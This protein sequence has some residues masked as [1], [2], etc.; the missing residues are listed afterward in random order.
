MAAIQKRTRNGKVSY[1]VRFYD[2]HGRERSRTFPT[3]ALAERFAATNTADIV[4][5]DWVDPTLAG[6]PF[7]AYAD[8]WLAVKRAE[9]KEQTADGYAADLRKYVT[10]RLGSVPV[11][12]ITPQ[13]IDGFLASLRDDGVSPHK[14][15][16]LLVKVVRPVLNHA[17]RDGAIKANPSAP[18]K[19]G[20]PRRQRD[21]KVLTA[22]QVTAL[23]DELPAPYDTLVLF[24]AYTGLRWGEVTGL[25]MKRLDLLAGRVEVAEVLQHYK[26]EARFSEPKTK[27]SERT[28]SLPRFL[29]DVMRAYVADRDLGPDDLVF[30][31]PRGK[32]LRSPNFLQKVYI[33]AVHR[34]LPEHLHGFRFH[35]LR[36]T[37]VALLIGA[38]AHPKEISTRMGH[39]TIMVTMDTYGHLLPSLDDRLSDGL[40]AAYRGVSA[41]TA[42]GTVVPMHRE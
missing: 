22:A 4:R 1:R 38:G 23:V 34:A 15:R 8:A 24:T 5:G 20:K 35:D 31:T 14:V 10:P 3:K 42:D 19:V 12:R 2:P 41:P 16:N 13:T 30:T 29:V 33:P 32:P 9:I 21:I 7:R 26:G 6:R 39:S 17:V 18:I 37:C 40:D 25:R 36:H 27:G 28:V 11:G